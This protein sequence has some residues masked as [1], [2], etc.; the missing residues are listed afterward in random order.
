MQSKRE[1]SPYAPEIRIPSVRV[2][3]FT[4]IEVLVVIAIIAILSAFLFPVFV[5][6]KHAAKQ[7]VCTSNLHQ[8][9]LA[10]GIYQQDNDGLYPA[11]TDAVDK[12]DVDSWFAWPEWQA[13]I[14]KLPLISDLL[15]SYVK[16][17]QVF[18]CP[19]DNGTNILDD[20]KNGRLVSSPSLFSKWGF[21]YKYRTQIALQQM[22]DSHFKVP[23]QV[24]LLRDATGAWHGIGRAATEQ[25][26][27]DTDQ[28]KAVERD[29]RYNTLFADQHI[30]LLT[31]DQYQ[32]V[33]SQAP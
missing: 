8:I 32:A 15:L 17:G 18:E 14:V 25:D 3:A 19:L 2:Y 31:F 33:A 30:K 16:A 6:A 22:S 21:S 13:Q 27:E 12:A 1:A 28:L 5:R 24:D 9:G 10:I 26:L 29:F 4:L 23:A 20:S 7:K 11:A